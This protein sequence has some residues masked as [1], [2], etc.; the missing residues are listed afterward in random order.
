[1]EKLKIIKQKVKDKI[2]HYIDNHKWEVVT[3][4]VILVIAIII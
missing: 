2:Q 3:V 1:M 4:G